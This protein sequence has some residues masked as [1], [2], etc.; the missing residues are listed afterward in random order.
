MD[1]NVSQRIRQA[2][3]ETAAIVDKFRA[4]FGEVRVHGARENGRQIGTL[5]L[6]PAVM[7][8]PSVPAERPKRLDEKRWMKHK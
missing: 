1:D 7:A 3:P 2:F 5:D 6:G 4:A 8:T